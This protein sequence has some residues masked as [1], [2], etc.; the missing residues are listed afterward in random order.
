MKRLRTFWGVFPLIFLLPIF[1]FQIIEAFM[2]W[3]TEIK[4]EM[5]YAVHFLPDDK[6]L[7][8]AVLDNFL[9]NEVDINLKIYGFSFLLLISI[10]AIFFI[11][12]SHI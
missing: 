3:K 4:E 2:A 7:K 12:L 5:I 10:G 11:L 1:L 8:T 9:K 6:K